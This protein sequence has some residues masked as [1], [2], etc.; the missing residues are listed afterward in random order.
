MKFNILCCVSTGGT[1]NQ[2][3][4]VI[5]S[6]IARHIIIIIQK[7]KTRDHSTKKSI[8]LANCIVPF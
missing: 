8:L 1:V 2:I 7:H 6:K 5:A 4:I 3:L